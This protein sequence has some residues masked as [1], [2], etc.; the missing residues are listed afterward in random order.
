MNATTPTL[1]VLVR[2][3]KQDAWLGVYVR[4]T[5]QAG[6]TGLESLASTR[7]RSGA[8][9]P[10]KGRPILSP[11]ILLCV[12]ALIHSALSMLRAV[13]HSQPR[14]CMPPKPRFVGLRAI[15]LYG[16]TSEFLDVVRTR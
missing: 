3:P 7:R 6:F 12:L 2:G 9:P 4:Q 14:Q 16:S 1:K 15:A 5:P 13:G 10:H 8:L 11:Y